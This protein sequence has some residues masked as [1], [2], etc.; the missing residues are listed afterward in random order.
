MKNRTNRTL[1]IITVFFISGY[2]NSALAGS[3]KGPDTAFCRAISTGSKILWCRVNTII[4]SQNLLTKKFG[5]YLKK[6]LKVEI[7]IYSPVITPKWTDE[8]EID[9]CKGGYTRG[10]KMCLLVRRHCRWVES[11]ED[12]KG[13]IVSKPRSE[14]K[15]TNV[16]ADPRNY[17]TLLCVSS[18]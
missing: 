10:S 1:A 9:S 15:T 18:K 5:V 3:C 7:P 16:P 4:Y 8:G 14:S 6:D 17:S 13:N 2:L 12:C 11:Y